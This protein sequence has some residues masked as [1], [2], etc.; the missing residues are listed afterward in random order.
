M[1]ALDGDRRPLSTRDAA[2]AKALAAAL[3][4]RRVAPNAIS[5]ASVLAA[6]LGGAALVLV[7]EASSMWQRAGLLVAAAAMIQL[8]LV[9]NL[10]DGMVAVEGGLRTK[11]GDVFN[12]LPDR[13]ADVF[14]IAGA[15]YAVREVEHGIEL[16]WIAASLALITAYVRVLG[17]AVGAG[18]SFLGPMAKQHRM[19]TL[20]VA[21]LVAAALSARDAA[22]FTA[23]G[24]GA[25]VLVAA[26]LAIALGCIWTIAR[27]V[28]RILRILDAP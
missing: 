4:K 9:C 6:V 15:G 28:R 21:C 8:R 26:L 18:T 22:A 16:G 14:L 2:W 11:T 12:D 3:A 1:V 17:K 10:L 23:S 5:I 27:R 7:P 13:L 20:T 24:L 19:A 25:R